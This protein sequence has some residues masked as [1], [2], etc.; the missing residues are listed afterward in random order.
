MSEAL[1]ACSICG[2]SFSFPE[3][4]YGNREDRSYFRQCDKEEK[5]AYG[6]GC[7]E[8]VRKFRDERTAKWKR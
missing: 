8:E 7:V 4:A 3:F 1:K 5:A 6:K 2:R